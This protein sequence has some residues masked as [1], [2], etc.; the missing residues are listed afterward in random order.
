MG[1]YKARIPRR[2]EQEMAGGNRQ[3]LRVYGSAKKPARFFIEYKYMYKRIYEFKNL[4]KAY[5]MARKCK[6]Y[7]RNIVDYGFFLESNLLRLQRE[8]IL[9]NYMPSSYVCFTVFEP[10]VRKV[11]APAFRDRVL[12]HSLVSQIEPLFESKFIYDSYACRKNK[13][14]HF[15]LKR[16]KK[17]L[18]AARSIYGK[19]TPIYCL[20]MDIEKFFASV[21]WDVLISIIN[22]TISCEKTKKLI[23]KIITK[24]RCFDINGNFIKASYDVVNPENRKGLPI[25]N[26]TSQLFANIYLNEL[27]HFVKETL[28]V[29]WYVRYMDD[30][31]VIHPD[32]NYLKKMR[33]AIKIFIEYELKLKFHP[34]KVIIQNVKTGLPFVGYLIF[35]DHVLIRG[36][37]L[38]RMRRRLKKRRIECM[39][40][41]DNKPLAASLSALRGHLRYANA[42]RLEKNLFEQPPVKLKV[43]KEK[44]INKQ[45]K[46]F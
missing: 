40:E 44:K 19:N 43:K 14:T 16:V 4:L 10:K 8:L 26:L 29:R 22:R 20:R 7:K 45:L 9:E 13:G 37:T 32:R 6:R 28:R 35:Y 39:E 38:L 23:E 12:Q 11:A 27:D 46:L 5:Q 17:F 34:K 41:N 2:I 24:H 1:E 31:L 33:E 3:R 30:F 36:S 15:G 25:G 42:Y 18:T 21:S